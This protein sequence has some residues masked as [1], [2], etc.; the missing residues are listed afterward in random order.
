MFSCS[1]D[2]CGKTARIGLSKHF[3]QTYPRKNTS[4]C[5]AVDI[6][7][8]IWKCGEDLL[9]KVFLRIRLHAAFFAVFLIGIKQ[10]CRTG[11]ISGVQLAVI[12]HERQ[13]RIRLFTVS[14]PFKDKIF[15]S[16]RGSAQLSANRPFPE[17]RFPNAFPNKN[18]PEITR[19]SGD[20]L[21]SEKRT[22][23]ELFTI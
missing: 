7:C 9:H 23:F 14:Q 3:T 5:N 10:L 6:P 21:S 13:H 4:F 8:H 12:L 11:T 16:Q 1:D 2:V 15:C 22:F 20:S 19:I 17:H 18:A